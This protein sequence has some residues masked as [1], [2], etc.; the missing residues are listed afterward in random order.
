MRQSMAKVGDHVQAACLVQ[1]P[2]DL[3]RNLLLAS[4]MFIEED[5]LAQTIKLSEPLGV[6]NE[7]L[8]C[9]CAPFLVLRLCKYQTSHANVFVSSAVYCGKR[10]AFVHS[11]PHR[12]VAPWRRSLAWRCS[13]ASLLLVQDDSSAGQAVIH[14]IECAAA[15]NLL[16]YTNVLRTLGF[17]GASIAVAGGVAAYLGDGSPLTTVKGAGPELDDRDVLAVEEFYRAHRHK[18]AVFELYPLTSQASLLRLAQRGYSPVATEDVVVR[19][20]PFDATPPQLEIAEVPLTEWPDLM[21][22]MNEQATGPVWHTLAQGSARLPGVMSLTVP[23]PEGARIACAQL[24]PAAGVALF[25]NDATHPSA[26]GRGA[27]TALIQHR[28]RLAAA[29]GFSC[30]AAEVAPGSI[31]QRNYLRCGFSVGYARTHWVR[32]LD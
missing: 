30:I 27:Q 1:S 26:R 22:A 3:L 32:T 23:D 20:A 13:G 15:Q 17:P 4:R 16:D 14:A 19:T 7:H 18:R 2:I 28:L 5:G 29:L 11:N 12:P 24:A 10:A 31:S 21:V 9:V 6:R 8:R 25:S